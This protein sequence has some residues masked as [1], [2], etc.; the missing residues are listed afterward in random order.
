MINT[1]ES[2]EFMNLLNKYDFGKNVVPGNAKAFADAVIELLEDKDHYAKMSENAR[3][4][5]EDAFDRKHSYLE[6]V[7]LADQLIEEK[8][9]G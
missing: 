6:M 9:H 8:K 2:E 3:K 1:L 5:A 4:L 7:H